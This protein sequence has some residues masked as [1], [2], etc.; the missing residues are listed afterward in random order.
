MNCRIKILDCTLRDGGYCN[1]WRFGLMNERRIV[2][3]LIRA[4]IDIIE[5]GLLCNEPYSGDTTRFHHIRNVCDILPKPELRENKIF[6]CLI[7]VG[8]FDVESLP[9]CDGSSIT[10]IRVAFHKE[11]MNQAMQ[12]CKAIKE[13]G[14]LVFVQ[15]MVS[16][17]Y[18]DQE[19]LNLIELCNEIEPYAFY[20]VDSFGSMKR[21]DVIRFYYLVEHNLKPQIRI[22]F[23]SHNNLQL[24]Y[25]NA[26]VLAGIDTDRELIVDCSIM[27]MGRGAG[28]VNTELFIEHLN[29]RDGDRYQVRP[30]LYMIDDIINVF[31]Q[32]KN[33]GYSVP[34][35]LSAVHNVHPNYASFL[36]ERNTLTI[37]DMD[38]LLSLIEEEKRSIFNRTYIEQLYKEYMNKP[39]Q[40][41]AHWNEFRADIK[42]KKILII[43]PGKSCLTEADLIKSFSQMEDTISISVNFEYNCFKTDYIFVSNLK[44]FQGLAPG[45][46]NRV[47]VTSNIDMPDAYLMINYE[48]YLCEINA[49]EDN[50]SIMLIKYL[51]Q[52][53]VREIYLAGMDGY[54]YDNEENYAYDS[55]QFVTGRAM[56]KE[57]NRGMQKMLQVFAQQCDLHFLT[58]QRHLSIKENKG[59]K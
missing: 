11:D 39:V 29:S 25:S 56:L 7:N 52:L 27:G 18:S 58:Q 46:K 33:W 49:I 2:E 55:M 28:N 36:S 34:N 53:G 5:C 22:G 40:K 6:V 59:E 4:N 42:G 19:F 12:I 21:R 35:Y 32:K 14:Y 54:N 37:Y 9:A 31:Y 51:I 30:V 15:P 20:I 16:L 26:Q 57:M 8:E 48:E 41:S 45:D 1:Q 47:I 38:D 10:G 17:R 44:R 50:A 23:H 3:G 24:A 43:A 13:K